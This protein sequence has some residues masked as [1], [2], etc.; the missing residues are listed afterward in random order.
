MNDLAV[1]ASRI[2]LF[3]RKVLPGCAISEIQQFKTGQ[4]NPTYLL[5]SNRGLLVLRAKPPGNLLPSAH[6][7]DREYRIM[8]GLQDTIVPVPQM[9]ALANDDNSPIG[10]A[11]FIMQFVDGEI[12][13]DPA[14]PSLGLDERRTVYAQMNSVLAAL[15]SLNPEKIGLGDFGKPGNYFSRQTYIWKR[16]YLKSRREPNELMDRLIDWLEKNMLDVDEKP[17]LVHGDFRID[18]II[19]SK[20][21]RTALAILDWELSTLGHPFADLAY[22]C[23]QWLMP[24][25]GPL[26]GLAG[27]NRASLGLPSEEEYVHDYCRRRSIGFPED[28]KFCLV[29]GLFRLAAILEGVARRAADGN[30]A[31]P[32]MAVAYGRSVPHLAETALSIADS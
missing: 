30:A 5:H 18:N 4:S 17:T 13:F 32:E 31:N 28:W 24:Y 21:D 25:D 15:H 29:F 26:K 11:F 19:F 1:T 9:I 20:S 16:Q 3:L 12:F 7:V 23:A 27:L 6:L 14:L 22:Q 8:R 2:E 10:R